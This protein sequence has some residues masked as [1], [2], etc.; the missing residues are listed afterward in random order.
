MPDCEKCGERVRELE[1]SGVRFETE[2]H[3]IRKDLDKIST[4]LEKMA[5]MSSDIKLLKKDISEAVRINEATINRVHKRIDDL[6][7]DMVKRIEKTKTETEQK[8]Q[9]TDSWFEWTTK[10]VFG[11]VIVAILAKIGLSK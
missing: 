4:A 9:K 10:I 1:H 7:A 3:A 6:E 11:V 5:D 2:F 8:I